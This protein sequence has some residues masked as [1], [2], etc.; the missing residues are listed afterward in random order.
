[1]NFSVQQYIEKLPMQVNKL[2]DRYMD[3]LPYITV[4]LLKFIWAGLMIY[5][6]WKTV[7]IIEH[8]ID[9]KENKK[10]TR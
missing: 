1:M 3:I 7:K 9:T 8:Y 6:S 2:E 10:E 5:F 4:P